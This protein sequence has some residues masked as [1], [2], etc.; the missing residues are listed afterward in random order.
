MGEADWAERKAGRVTV[1]KGVLI[2]PFRIIHI[3]PTFD[4]GMGP[5]QVSAGIKKERGT[6]MFKPKYRNLVI[7]GNGF[8]R[9]QGLPTAYDEFRK[10]YSAHLDETMN[11]LG[12]HSKTISEPDGTTK[13]VTPVELVYGDPFD[14]QKLP[15]E[16]FWSFETSLDKMDDQQLILY[17]GRTKKGIDQLQETVE[18]AQRSVS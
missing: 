9:W 17:F 10:Y 2:V 7:I 3:T 12:I 11:D 4:E 15:S 16:F 14:P 8:D 5:R 6:L 13:T 18:Q 1:G